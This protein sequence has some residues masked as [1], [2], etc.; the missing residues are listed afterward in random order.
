MK[1]P[2]VLLLC[3]TGW[4]STKVIP[5]LAYFSSCFFRGL[6]M[7]ISQSLYVV[8]PRHLSHLSRPFIVFW[9]TLYV[10]KCCQHVVSSSLLNEVRT[11]LFKI[12]DER[13]SRGTAYIDLLKMQQV[14]RPSDVLA[15]HG[16]PNWFQCHLTLD[17]KQCWMDFIINR[18]ACPWDILFMW[19]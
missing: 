1:H 11:W 7:L 6:M 16:I 2:E 15:E 10:L 19:L 8:S 9:V 12:D 4:T 17:I 14:K 18:S 5:P 3:G 13:S